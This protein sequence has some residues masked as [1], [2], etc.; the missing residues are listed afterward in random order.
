MRPESNIDVYDILG[1]EQ[2]C[3]CVRTC[4]AQGGP[5]RLP[6]KEFSPLWLHPASGTF[7]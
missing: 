2:V 4:V 7:K 5:N 3:A 6:D 1:C